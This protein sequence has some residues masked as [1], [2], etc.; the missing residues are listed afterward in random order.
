MPAALHS[1]TRTVTKE[2]VDTAYAVV[3]GLKLAE[4]TDSRLVEEEAHRAALKEAQAKFEQ[5][6]AECDWSRE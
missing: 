4:M 2:Q 6:Y 5:L 1:I 3:R